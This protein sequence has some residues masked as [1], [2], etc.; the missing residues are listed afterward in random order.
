MPVSADVRAVPTT[1]SPQEPPATAAPPALVDALRRLEASP[2]L[3]RAARPLAAAAGRVLRS[4][5]VADGLRGAWLG[6]ALHPLLT[7]F[8]LG[9]WSSASFLDL[10]GGRAAR[11]A[12]RRLVGFGLLASLPTALSGL[13]ERQSVPGRGARRVGV[14]HAAVNSAATVLYGCSWVA[15]RRGRHGRAVA[16]GV[17]GGVVATAAGYL[18]GHLSLVRKLGTADPDF[19]PDGP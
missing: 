18:G 3:D 10:F 12:A 2:V 11:P 15:R 13:A 19:G 14:V 4:P 16:L 6:H 9:A 8:P 7:D 5:S 1:A 17:A